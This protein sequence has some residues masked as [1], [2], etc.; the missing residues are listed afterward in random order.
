MAELPNDQKSGIG[1]LE[2]L[3]ENLEEKIENTEDNSNELKED[4]KNEISNPSPNS[5]LV[6][7]LYPNE[8]GDFEIGKTYDIKWNCTGVKD[9]DII[10]IYLF[11]KSKPDD[12]K[13]IASLVN[14]QDEQYSWTISEDIILKDGEYKIQ[15]RRIAGSAG[16]I[17]ESDNYFSVKSSGSGFEKSGYMTNWNSETEKYT[18]NWNF[19]YSSPGQNNTSKKIIFD[20]NSLCNLSGDYEKCLDVNFDNSYNGKKIKITGYSSND[21]LLISKLQLLD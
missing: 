14:C 13:S 16:L 11:Q 18:E 1:D 12:L 19:N 17:D 4:E 21:E 9:V 6:S 7:V 8:G 2:K 3:N 5:G 15:I 20:S 10:D